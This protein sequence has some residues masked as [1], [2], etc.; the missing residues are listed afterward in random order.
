MKVTG[1][2][3]LILPALMVGGEVLAQSLEPR[4]Y[5]N[6]PVG[7][8]FFIAG[9]VY[10]TGGLA[11]DPDLP[12]KD[13]HLRVRAPVLAYA[14]SLDAW[15]KSAKFDAI[16]PG[17]C[18]DGSAEVNGAVQ[19]RDVCGLIDPAFRFSMN[20]YGAPA[21]SLKEFANYR[22]D[23]IVGASLQVIAPL[24]QYD[25]TR[26]V[27]LGTNRWTFRPE[28]G[29]SKSFGALS[30]ELALDTSIFTTNHE[31]F[32]G[33]VREQNPMYSAQAHVV[34]QFSNRVWAAVNGTFYTGGETT[35]NGVKQ[36]DRQRASRVGATLAI[37]VDRQNSI[38]LYASSGLSIRTGTDFDTLGIAWQYR[39]GGG[40]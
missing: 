31:F 35:I 27:N 5:T 23:V 13:A 33:K 37:S 6:V 24:G 4:A 9:F 26:L 29:V 22:Q 30:V 1:A 12:I 38:K 32:G 28:I 18:L 19:T 21:L 3:W 2:R 39:W 16:V 40:L 17:G 20:F 7:M 25:P 15:G 14:R 34:Y 11:T 10:S 36:D 8:N